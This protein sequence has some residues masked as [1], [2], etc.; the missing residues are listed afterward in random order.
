[1]MLPLALLAGCVSMAASK[2][3]DSPELGIPFQYQGMIAW[4]FIWAF[5]DA[6][7]IGANDVANAFANAVGAGTVSH[8]GACLI[9][10][11]F[12][13]IGVIALGA[14]VT[15]TISKKVT[16]VSLFQH[17]PYV[18]ALGMSFVNVGSGLW[19]IVATMFSMP[20]S[21][22]H[23][24]VGAVMG[25]GIAAWGPDGVVWAY[26]EKGF[27]SVLASWFISPVT[28]GTLAAI[29]YMFTKVVVLKL[30]DDEAF[31]MG[32]MLMPFYFF[33]VFGT[34]WGFMMMKGIPA[35]E[36]APYEMTVPITVGLAV[37]HAIHGFFVIIPWLRRTIED[38]ENLPWYT[39]F[40]TPCV[41]KGSHGYYQ[42]DT[43]GSKLKGGEK[44]ENVV[45]VPSE[46]VAGGNSDAESEVVSSE[47]GAQKLG[48]LIAPGLFMSVGAARAEDADMHAA[49]FV[50][51]SKTEEMFKF[52]QL[53]SCC[54]FSLAHGAN[55]VANSVGPF[56]SVWAIYSTGTVAT[57]ANVPLWVL[58]YGGLALDFGLISMGHHIMAALGN[59]LTL[60]TPSRGFCIELGAMFSVMVASRI[61]VPVSTT[62]CITG[63]T[64][65]VGL[66]NGNFSSLNW[67]LFLVIFFGWIITCP[68]AGLLAGLPFWAVAGAPHPVPQNGFFGT[69]PATDPWAKVTNFHLGNRTY[70]LETYKVDFTVANGCSKLYNNTTSEWLG[71]WNCTLP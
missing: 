50:A 31:K 17:D 55:D 58:V 70:M 12:E 36:S 28:S 67:P 59:R 57:K 47:S 64:V 7:S 19:V 33:F 32:I 61:G 69:D 22:T 39:A 41:A 25:I 13:L 42:T 43:D 29:F 45:V 71:T 1:M 40:Y 15:D 63:A 4:A 53:T 27:L 24:V 6:Y 30:P 16:D 49:A 21:T 18:L 66:C 60:Q 46:N 14:K 3:Y 5:V 48:K 44:G 20:V 54:F 34:I 35:L 68:L 8:R 11:V 51:G 9:A 65:G 2:S 38:Y 52:L 56:S 26:D 37:F 23:S 62:F 10:C